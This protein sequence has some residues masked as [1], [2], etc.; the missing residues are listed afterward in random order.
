MYEY[1]IVIPYRDKYDFLLKAIESIPDRQDIQIIIVDNSSKELPKEKIPVKD[2]SSLIYCTSDP[3]KGAGCA[4]NVGCTYVKGNHVFFMDA[5]DY[6]TAEAFD[7]FDKYKGCDEDI[8]FFRSGSVRILTGK[9]SSRHLYY[10]ALIEKYKET[11]NEDG[12]RFWFTVPW[13]KLYKKDLILNEQVYF[14]EVCASNDLMFS[15]RAGFLAKKIAVDDTVVYIV[16]EGE[17]NQSID[18]T[19]SSKAQ[20]ARFQVA[21]SQYKY[22]EMIGRKDMRFHLLS[23][24]LRS[25]KDFGPI[26]FVKYLSYAIKNKVWIF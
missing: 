25:L 2:Y 22:M 15:C 13:C 16:T 17:A 7:A 12:L 3:E 20:F 14:D 21:V 23:Y 4:R 5:D 9:E 19:R 8:I 26:E 11:G 6:F 18:K 1:S 10:N 24:V